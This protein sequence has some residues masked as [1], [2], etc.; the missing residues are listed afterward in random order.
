MKKYKNFV[1][2]I[3][4]YHGQIFSFEKEQNYHM[5]P[6]EVMKEEWFYCEIFAIDAWVKIE[7]DPN[8]VTG[9]KVIY[10]KNIFQY[11]LFL[12]RRRNA[13]MYSNTL[14]L[15][16]LVVWLIWKRAIFFAH[17]Q[18]L[19]LKEKVL[20]NIVVAFFYRFFSFIRC[21][22]SGE[23]ELLMEKCIE[24]YVLPLSVSDNFYNDNL[25]WRSGGF[26]IGN[27]YHDKDPEFLIRTCKILQDKKIDFV[28]EIAWED[29][30]DKDGK[31]FS[32]LIKENN[33]EN[34]IKILGFI[35]HKELQKKLNTS[36]FFINTSISE[37]QCL[38]AY[39]AALAG[40]SL[41]L[42]NILSFPSVFK[43]NALYHNVPEQLAS[44]IEYIIENPDERKDMIQKNS[45]MILKDYSFNKIKKNTKE[46]FLSLEK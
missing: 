6:L 5:L 2:I 29:R 8:F 38:A 44:N 9:V 26:F 33:L 19:P 15:K 16:T 20:K 13:I 43:K 42:A 41:C 24:S 32:D 46:M 4:W 45:K 21:I 1:S 31:N 35:P 10:Y 37:W 17:D 12:W 25:G 22:N 30:Y 23:K 18:A 3:W 40:C 11:L 39:E 34:Y 36:L 7:D 28:I 14:T 27:L